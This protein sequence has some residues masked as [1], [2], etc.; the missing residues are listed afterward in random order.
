MTVNLLQER[1][2]E[3]NSAIINIVGNKMHIIGFFNEE[4]LISHLENGMDNWRSKGMY[5]KGDISFSNIKSNAL[6][7][8]KQDEKVLE[9]H[10]FTVYKRPTVQRKSE[11]GSIILTIRK[12]EFID[13]WQIIVLNKVHNFSSKEEM[14]SHFIS[15]YRFEF[16]I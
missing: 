1:V 7:I 2:N 6:F 3:L 5:D 15:N 8:L 9:K 12:H 4:R 13:Q 11:S 14:E 10:K 16:E